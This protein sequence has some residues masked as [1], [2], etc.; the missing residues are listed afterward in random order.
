MKQ[1]SSNWIGTVHEKCTVKALYKHAGAMFELD[2]ETMAFA[3]VS[4]MGKKWKENTLCSLIILF[5]FWEKKKNPPDKL[6]GK[7]G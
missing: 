2:G 6:S 1:L 5:I 4:C 7:A 3:L